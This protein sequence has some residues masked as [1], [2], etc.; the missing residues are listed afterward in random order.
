MLFRSCQLLLDTN[1]SHFGIDPKFFK[2][3]NMEERGMQFY[4]RV[5]KP[6]FFNNLNKNVA[7][8]Y[9]YVNVTTPET[10][11]KLLE[12]PKEYAPNGVY[13]VRIHG[14]FVNFLDLSPEIQQDIIMRLDLDSTSLA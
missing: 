8:F 2:A 1:A 5:I 12:N 11:K 13:I 6:L 4:Q 9:I 7:P 3:D 10:L 14:T